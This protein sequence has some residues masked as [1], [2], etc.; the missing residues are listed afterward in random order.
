MDRVVRVVDRSVD[1]LATLAGILMVALTTVVMA[2]V[3]SRYLLQTPIQTTT[4]MSGLIFAWLV[5]L[6]A[7]SV[8][9]RQDNIA[10]TYFRDKLP[11]KLPEVA[12]VLM[13]IIMLSFCLVLAWSSL[14]LT[15]AVMDQRLPSLQISTAWLNASVAVTF[16][17]IS[18][19]LLLQIITDIFFRHLRKP[20]GETIDPS[21]L[22]EGTIKGGAE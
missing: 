14:Q 9:H 16:A 17:V 15:T 10:V 4:G 22:A 7:I 20:V 12:E 3:I 11:G 13:K 21:E 1:A 19:V 2:A 18:V 8:T 5:F 6:A